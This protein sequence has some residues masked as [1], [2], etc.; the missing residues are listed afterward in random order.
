MYYLGTSVDY[1]TGLEDS[2]EPT[3]QPRTKEFLKLGIAAV[4]SALLIGY[5]RGKFKK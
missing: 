4:G 1:A 2:L 5:N 3:P